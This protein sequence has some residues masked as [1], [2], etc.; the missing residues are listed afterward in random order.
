MCLHS[1]YYTCVPECG[2]SALVGDLLLTRARHPGKQHQVG[3][4][5]VP[6]TTSHT[7]TNNINHRPQQDYYFE[8]ALIFS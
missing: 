7:V 5:E 2:L 3:R 8:L 4:L 1:R 6:V